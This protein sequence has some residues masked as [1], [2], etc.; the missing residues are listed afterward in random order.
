MTKTIRKHCPECN[1]ENAV[2]TPHSVTKDTPRYRPHCNKCQY[3]RTAERERN[4][5]KKTEPKNAAPTEYMIDNAFKS[6]PCTLCWDQEF[7]R[8]RTAAG[9]DPV[10]FKVNIELPKAR[11]YESVNMDFH[12]DRL[13]A[14]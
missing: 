10:C 1:K 3:A 13:E 12:V 7:C 6:S 11:Y 9:L 14:R 4:R 2:F 5:I 8:V